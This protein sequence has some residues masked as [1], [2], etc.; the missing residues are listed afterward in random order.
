[1]DLTIHEHKDIYK[2]D[3][4]DLILE[5]QQKEFGIS[6]RKED[7]PDLADIKNFYQVGDGN[8]GVALCDE[9]I[10]GTI[11]LKDIGN[12]QGA[13]RKMFVKAEYRGKDIRTAQYLLGRV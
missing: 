4:I 9:K 10:V 7:Q 11:S 5:I 8:F 13:L 6:I 2:D 3:I 12:Q 1:M